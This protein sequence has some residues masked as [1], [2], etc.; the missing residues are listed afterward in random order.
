[1]LLKA[2]IFRETWHAIDSSEDPRGGKRYTIPK[3]EPIDM[4]ARQGVWANPETN[5]ELSP[6]SPADVE[7]DAS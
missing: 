7:P 1:M 6:T 2:K 5:P 3:P 4:T